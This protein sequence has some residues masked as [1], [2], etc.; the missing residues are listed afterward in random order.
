[1]R[2]TFGRAVVALAL[3]LAGLVG[4][5]LL[6]PGLSDAAVV[7]AVVGAFLALTWERPTFRGAVRLVAAV[8]FLIFIVLDFY[9]SLASF[10]L[11]PGINLV[12]TAGAEEEIYHLINVE[13]QKRGLDPLSYDASLAAGAKYWACHL[14]E[15]HEFRHDPSSWGGSEYYATGEN[16]H[17]ESY[18]ILISDWLARHTVDGWMSSPHHRAIMLYPYF[19]KVGVGCCCDSHACIC[20][21]RF[22]ELKKRG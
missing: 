19:D 12:D 10:G 2:V 11:V 20:V 14:L 7:A 8:L 17:L 16:L 22:G 5:V 15:A 1:M 21:A 3:A 13:R 4:V 18:D 9:L 6:P